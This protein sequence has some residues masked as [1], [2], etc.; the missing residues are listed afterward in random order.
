MSNP[1]DY[2][3]DFTTDDQGRRVFVGLTFE[4]TAE[5]DDYIAKDEA[6][7]DAKPWGGW[8]AKD[9]ATKRYLNLWDKHEAARLKLFGDISELPR[10]GPSGRTR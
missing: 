1:T 8:D 6:A 3:R 10:I 4:E 2:F 9:A 7:H 5:I